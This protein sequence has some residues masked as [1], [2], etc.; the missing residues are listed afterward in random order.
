M[1]H[2]DD[3]DGFLGTTYISHGVDYHASSDSGSA[4]STHEQKIAEDKTEDAQ[5]K[6]KHAAKHHSG[7]DKE[8]LE[9]KAEMAA[10]ETRLQA[11]EIET[12]ERLKHLERLN[13]HPISAEEKVFR[14]QEES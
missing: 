7:E 11:Y 6:P 12:E 2:D 3:A 8:L 9:L 1:A 5:T 4:E 14:I 13:G 10:L